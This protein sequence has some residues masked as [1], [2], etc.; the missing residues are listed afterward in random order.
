M[1]ANGGDMNK[2]GFS[3]LGVLVAIGLV[4]I[5]FA[6][7][8]DMMVISTKAQR[9]Q[10]IRSDFNQF[11]ETLRR[12]IDHEQSCTLAVTGM[13]Y[14]GPLQMRDPLVP[15]H[16]IAE[17][18]RPN[19]LGWTLERIQLVDLKPVP[20]QEGVMR[21]N[22]ELVARKNPKLV[23]G[24]PFVSTHIDGIYF[25]VKKTGSNISYQIE[26]CFG[27][28]GWFSTAEANCKL[29]GG[30]WK[31]DKPGAQCIIFGEKT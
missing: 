8:A 11:T 14:T 10:A 15:S 29:L 21:G 12:I 31:G 24:S 9:S 27:T 23:L 20:N 19:P 13:D 3:V 28:D 25:S 7:L 4:S 6:A 22:L 5:M 2:S 1:G 16:I 30:T 18:G 17:I 26:K